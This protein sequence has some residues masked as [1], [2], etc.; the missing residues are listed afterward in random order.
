MLS[1]GMKGLTHDRYHLCRC[2]RADNDRAVR[3]RQLAL[4]AGAE[5]SDAVDAF[6]ITTSFQHCDLVR[7]PRFCSQ[8]RSFFGDLSAIAIRDWLFHPNA[9]ARPRRDDDPLSDIHWGHLSRSSN[10]ASLADCENFTQHGIVIDPPQLRDK[11]AIAAVPR[12]VIAVR[13]LISVGRRTSDVSLCQNDLI[14]GFLLMKRRFCQEEQ[15]W[16]RGN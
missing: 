1:V 7:S 11:Q 16:A 4:P 14:T 10:F 8:P 15:R 6:A 12:A 5:A 3:S 9:E 13:P 2:H